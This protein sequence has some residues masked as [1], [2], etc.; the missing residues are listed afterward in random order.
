MTHGNN[1]RKEKIMVRNY[2]YIYLFIGEEREHVP[3][4][5]FGDKSTLRK[6]ALSFHQ[7]RSRIKLRTSGPWT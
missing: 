7:V 2:D 5:A 4:Q 1:K 6:S 3:L